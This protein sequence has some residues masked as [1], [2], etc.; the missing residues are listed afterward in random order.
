MLFL[1][2]LR[3]ASFHFPTPSHL[4][5]K[6]IGEAAK[7][8]AENGKKIALGLM[9]GHMDPSMALAIA[10]QAGEN[11]LKEGKLQGILL[12]E[13]LAAAED[14]QKAQAGGR[15]GG[16]KE[17]D[18]EENNSEDEDRGGGGDS[19]GQKRKYRKDDGDG[20]GDSNSDDGGGGGS[21]SGGGGGNGVDPMDE[22]AQQVMAMIAQPSVFPGATTS[23]SSSASASSSRSS[24]SSVL[25]RRKRT[26]SPSPIIA[27]PLFSVT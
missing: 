10:T 15:G 24:S 23:S 2:Q 26:K 4:S 20:D 14:R 22:N 27:P 1:T 9:M 13:R 21:G 19:G 12:A 5:L 3:P 11:A 18:E 6:Q 17:G 25:V 8:S 7:Q 16:D